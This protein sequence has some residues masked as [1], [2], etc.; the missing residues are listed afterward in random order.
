MKVDN[1][2]YCM[3]GANLDK[4]MIEIIVFKVSTLLACATERPSAK[5]IAM[6]YLD[7]IITL[8]YC[9]YLKTEKG[10]ILGL[11]ITLYVNQSSGSSSC[12]GIGLPVELIATA[13]APTA[14]PATAAGAAPNALGAVG[15]LL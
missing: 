5:K 13:P 15:A 11:F 4:L 8:Q 9:I 1:C 12:A 14:A 2:M 6:K 10:P 7:D 3:K